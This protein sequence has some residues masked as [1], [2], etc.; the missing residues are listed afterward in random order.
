MSAE[1]PKTWI[2]KDYGISELVSEGIKSIVNDEVHEALKDYICGEDAYISLCASDQSKPTV[3][4]YAA[5][6]GSPRLQKSID[7][8]DLLQK[9]IEGHRPAG[10][11]DDETFFPAEGN[12]ELLLAQ[13]LL[14]AYIDWEKGTLT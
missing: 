10:V 5:D 3:V 9:E 2:A 6:G 4:F 14:R 7:L 1:Q 12:R 8:V 11:A 13:A